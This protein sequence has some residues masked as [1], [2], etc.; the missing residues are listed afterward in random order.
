MYNCEVC[1]AGFKGVNGKGN[2][3]CSKLC[4][5]EGQRRKRESNL[6]VRSCLVCKHEFKVHKNDSKKFCKVD[7]YRA[8]QKTKEYADKYPTKNTFS[9]EYCSKTI[10]GGTLSTKRDGTKSDKK[11]CDRS[12]YDLYREKIAQESLSCE[13]LNCKAPV[14]PDSKYCS[15]S[16]CVKHKRPEPVSCVGCGA[17]FTAVRVFDNR[18]AFVSDAKTCSD[19]CLR[20]FYRDNEERKKKISEAFTGDKHPNWQGGSSYVDGGKFRGSNWRSIRLKVIAR[21]KNKCEHCGI[22]IEEQIDRY[23]RGFSVNHKKPFHQFGGDTS[24]ANR[25]SNLEC[26]CDSCHTKADWDYRKNNEMQE[27]I[28]W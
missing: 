22:S 28:L 2:K 11:F 25:L 21:A 23:G 1:G 4:L 8:F 24:K 14:K 17:L 13:C 3:F 5:R 18:I 16:C 15:M 12:C 27:V 6:E 7:C 20:S 10:L 19:S 9:C 26:L